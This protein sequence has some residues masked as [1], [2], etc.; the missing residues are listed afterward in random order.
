MNRHIGITLLL[1]SSGGV[2]LLTVAALHWYWYKEAKRK[3]DEEKASSKVSSAVPDLRLSPTAEALTCVDI[4]RAQILSSTVG[5]SS[6]QSLESSA[7]SSEEFLPDVNSEDETLEGSRLEGD[8]L[9]DSF[10]ISKSNLPSPSVILSPT[11]AEVLVNVIC[12]TPDIGRQ[13][14]CLVSVG[15]CASFSANQ[16][17]LRRAGIIPVLND[18]IKTN[19]NTDVKISAIKALGNLAVNEENQ[20]YMEDSVSILVDL[21]CKI[22]GSKG[23]EQ[24]IKKSALMSLTNLSVTPK[25]HDT[26][27]HL[28]PVLLK[29]LQTIPEDLSVSESLKI[30]VNMSSNQAMGFK[31]IQCHCDTSKFVDFF[32]FAAMNG[33]AGDGGA[34]AL[35]MCYLMANLTDGLNKGFQQ[36]KSTKDVAGEQ[37]VPIQDSLYMLISDKDKSSR[38]RNLLMSLTRHSDDGLRQQ[39]TRLYTGLFLFWGRGLSQSNNFGRKSSPY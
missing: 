2:L 21:L 32:E 17:L 23:K 24:E 13:I 33:E 27:F 37:N 26:I 15:N 16:Y 9:D 5:G 22:E 30:L 25:F 7:D 12:N 36:N 11:E 39:A 28:I 35:R 14:R 20:E 1:A 3:T 8:V 4:T 29:M 19:R 34:N 18:L 10:D 6:E 38:L 31:M